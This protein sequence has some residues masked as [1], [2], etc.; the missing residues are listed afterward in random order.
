MLSVTSAP[1]SRAP[2][3]LPPAPDPQE[4]PPPEASAANADSALPVA[5]GLAPA[6]RSAPLPG[7]RLLAL[8]PALEQQRLLA[9]AAPVPLT[10]GEAL[11]EPGVD[12]R[13]LYF[14]VQGS[15]S[16]MAQLP[17]HPGL[18]V[19]LVGAEGMLG[20]HRVLGVA[21]TP[22][23]AQVQSRGTAW[24]VP[25]GPFALVL[26]R[27]PV[28]HQVLDRYLAV[29]LAQLSMAAACLRYH[30]IG[31]RLARWLLMS[32]DRAG[33]QRLDVT[34]EDLA[35]LLGVRRV[36]ITE[37]AGRLQR[38]GLIRYHRGDLTVLDRPGLQAVACSC[39]AAD[40]LAYD[41]LLPVP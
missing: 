18:E 41:A 5:T 12:G 22:W 25:G 32:H 11:F 4:A 20:L 8:L 36:G 24:R 7:N 23:R 30:H 6:L 35:A 28:L 38:Q 33:G 34:H 29:R 16:L 9:A 40:C 15:V 3:P 31:P 10:P 39:Y 19:G 17:G 2:P 27:S 21:S 13:S 14:P 1:D 37:A 26:A